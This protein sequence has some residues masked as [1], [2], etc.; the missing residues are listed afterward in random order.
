MWDTHIPTHTHQHTH[1]AL[2]GNTLW[3]LELC[4]IAASLLWVI[5]SPQGHIC[6][7]LSPPHFPLSCLSVSP[8]LSLP[9]SLS[10]H[11]LSRTLALYLSF[12]P[13]LPPPVSF[14]TCLSTALTLLLPPPPVDVF[15]AKCSQRIKYLQLLSL[16]G[17]YET[18][19]IKSWLWTRLGHNCIVADSQGLWGISRPTWPLTCALILNK[20]NWTNFH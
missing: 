6:L 16:V 2:P 1:F 12:P 10:H 13:F 18:H 11:L 7:P 4:L 9:V 15:L 20:N 19:D 5:S 17:A 14:S 8:S 3:N